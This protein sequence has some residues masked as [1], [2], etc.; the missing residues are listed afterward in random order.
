MDQ[1]KATIVFDV[2]SFAI[3]QDCLRFVL[4]LLL[5]CYVAYLSIRVMLNF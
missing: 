5:E 2:G 4:I 1:F 3:C